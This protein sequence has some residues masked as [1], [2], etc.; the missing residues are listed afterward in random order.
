MDVR[1][2][3][4]IGR[5]QFDQSIGDFASGESGKLLNEGLRGG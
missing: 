2:V 1:N 3:T 4:A 5:A